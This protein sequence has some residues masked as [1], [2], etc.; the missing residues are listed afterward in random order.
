MCADDSAEP[1]HSP[2]DSKSCA[3]QRRQSRAEPVFGL[4][5]KLQQWSPMHAL[6]LTDDAASV[7]LS[8][9]RVTSRL[10]HADP[11]TLR[12]HSLLRRTD[13]KFVLR[14]EGI[15]LLLASVVENYCLLPKGQV[16]FPRYRTVYFDTQ[17]LLAFNDHRRGRRP[18]HKVRTRHYLDR[19][20]SYLEIKTKNA[21]R[22]TEKLREPRAFGDDELTDE[23]LAVIAKRTGWKTETMRPVMAMEFSRLTLFSRDSPERMTIDFQLRFGDGLQEAR[24]EQL[25]IVEIKQPQLQRCT[26]IMRALRAH[27]CRPRSVSKY[28]TAVA[29][30]YPE[31]PNNRL[32][33]TLRAIERL[34]L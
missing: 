19:G 1:V 26:P 9:L 17:D 18:R 13:T 34:E 21:N 11:A 23:N 7:P 33:P 16:V 31:I 3:N 28:C 30:T 25:A 27:G 14:S 32:R 22:V 10:Q 8:L 20:I 6:P 29:L 12:T 4:V 5:H 2:H 24:L 15:P